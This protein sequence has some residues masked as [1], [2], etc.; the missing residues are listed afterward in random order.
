MD[1]TDTIVISINDPEESKI[2]QKYLFTK[3]YAWVTFG[4]R[5]SNIIHTDKP[6]LILYQKEREIYFTY[7][8]DNRI[9]TLSYNKFRTTALVDEL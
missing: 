7:F 3:G 4:N 1:S 5:H 2:I 9:N 6:Y 8:I